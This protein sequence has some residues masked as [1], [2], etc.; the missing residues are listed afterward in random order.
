VLAQ[1][2]EEITWRG[3]T[4]PVKNEKVRVFILRSQQSSREIEQ[5]DSY[6]EKMKVFTSLLMD[7]Q[8]A[9]QIIKDELKADGVR[10]HVSYYIV[11]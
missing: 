1:R 5:A 8:D 2:H 10:S 4:I 6:E 3:Q 11:S 7:C 9:Q